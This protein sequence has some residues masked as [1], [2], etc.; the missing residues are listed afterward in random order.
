LDY[1]FRARAAKLIARSF[2]VSAQPEE[3]ALV[4]AER[5]ISPGLKQE[6]YEFQL[7]IIEA[8]EMVAELPLNDRGNRNESGMG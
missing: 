4:R 1:A 7:E 5:R 6:G 3:D 2:S 8:R